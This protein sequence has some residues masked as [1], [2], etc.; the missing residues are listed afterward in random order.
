MSR[1]RPPE[2]LGAGLCAFGCRRK[3]EKWCKGCNL[4]YCGGHADMK[5]H[6]CPRLDLQRGCPGTFGPVE[7]PKKRAKP[8][9]AVDAS[10]DGKPLPPTPQGPELFPPKEKTNGQR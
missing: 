2:I 10:T 4:V 8:K 5:E 9:P 7:K 3:W 6:N 1:N